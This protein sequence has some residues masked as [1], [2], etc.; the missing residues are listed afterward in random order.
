MKF[1]SYFSYM[2]MYYT[3]NDKANNLLVN[4]LYIGH[5]WPRRRSWDPENEY[6]EISTETFSSQTETKGTTEARRMWV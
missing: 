4:T 3:Q 5:P 6:R 1:S 2:Y